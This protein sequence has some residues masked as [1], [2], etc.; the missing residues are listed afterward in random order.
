MKT[1]TII[2]TSLVVTA[3]LLSACGGGGSSSSD[4]TLASSFADEMGLQDEYPDDYQEPTGEE[5]LS[6]NTTD[7]SPDQEVKDQDNQNTVEYDTKADI[8]LAQKEPYFKYAWHLSSKNSALND[9]GYEIDK[10]ADI[11]I[12]DAWRLTMGQNV[13]VAVID[14]GGEVNHEEIKANLFKAYNAD[15]G[16]SDVSVKNEEGSHGNT[17]AGCIVSSI[18]G[19]G[20]VGVAPKAQL[21]IIRQEEESDANVIKAFEYAKDQGAKVISCSWG[22]NDVSDILV[23]ELKSIYDAGITVLFASGNEGDSLDKDGVNDES[24]VEWVIGV[25]ASVENNDVGS[26]S[27]YGKNIDI[28]APAGDTQESSGLLGIDDMGERGGENQL[29][30]VN[31]NYQFVDGTSFATPISAGVVALMY[32]INPTITPKQVRE[33]LIKT[34]SKVGQGYDDNGFEE[35]RAYGKINAGSAVAEAQKLYLSKLN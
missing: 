17:C 8:A 6:Q 22:T 20:Y 23:S 7:N 33:I 2:K 26:Y 18:N 3:L 10:S 12:T 35:R 24:E 11:N 32:S 31:N 21:I 16:S 27:N 30:I 25:G 34:A 13:K 19:K 28:I 4:D 15:D 29:G 9:N 5:D 1:T 14:D